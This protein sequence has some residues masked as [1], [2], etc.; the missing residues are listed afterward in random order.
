LSVVLGA[1]AGQ[2]T[3]AELGYGA[4]KIEAMYAS[5]AAA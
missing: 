5:G 2:A 3:L 1:T 4:D